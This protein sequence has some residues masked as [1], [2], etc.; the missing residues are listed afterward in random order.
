MS[1]PGPEEVVRWEQLVSTTPWQR[2]PISEELK[3]KCRV[4]R[5]KHGIE[6]DHTDYVLARS[7]E[8]CEIE[9]LT[10]D[11]QVA[12]EK[13]LE[14]YAKELSEILNPAIAEAEKQAQAVAYYETGKE[15]RIRSNRYYEKNQSE[16]P[17]G[18]YNEPG[19][20]YIEFLRDGASVVYFPDPELTLKYSR[21]ELESYRKAAEENNHPNAIA[22]LIMLGGEGEL[23]RFR[24]MDGSK[25]GIIAYGRRLYGHCQYL[26]QE[27]V[28]SGL[29]REEDRSEPNDYDLG[30]LHQNLDVHFP[31]IYLGY[32]HYTDYYVGA[33]SYCLP[34]IMQM[35]TDYL[36]RS[37]D[38]GYPAAIIQCC[39]EGIGGYE[40]DDSTKIILNY[41]R[42]IALDDEHS[43]AAIR[44]NN[45]W[46]FKPEVNKASAHNS[47]LTKDEIC[48]VIDALGSEKCPRILNKN[49]HLIG[50]LVKASTLSLEDL[51]G[52]EA[53]LREAIEAENNRAIKAK[54]SEICW[55][56]H[57]IK[58]TEEMISGA[59]KRARSLVSTI[60]PDKSESILAIQECIKEV[61][62]AAVSGAI[63][64]EVVAVGGGGG[65][66]GFAAAAV[67]EYGAGDSGDEE[68]VPTSV[69]RKRVVGVNRLGVDG[70]SKSR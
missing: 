36:L 15:Y 10:I 66:G 63:G 5:K 49:S 64:G 56:F 52:I 19:V 69:A 55:H 9:V 18:W 31:A 41:A 44:Q 29:N 54:M 53:K 35:S 27:S 51:N 25:D 32:R 57:V 12:S 46:F 26:Y 1:R 48:E 68:G 37:A 45:I 40:K 6:I 42:A 11:R 17:A 34:K 2:E 65:G 13:G 43:H 61:N 7:K 70:E 30:E 28:K 38:A 33:P 67:V 14:E 21:L 22:K 62:S 24:E 4:L 3:E 39:R 20:K 60:D 16:L 23:K 47:E 58:R 50:D 8:R 59:E